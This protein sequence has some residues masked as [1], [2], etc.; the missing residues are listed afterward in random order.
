MRVPEDTDMVCVG[1]R[2]QR[3]GSVP[4]GTSG[5]H[6]AY[7]GVVRNSGNEAAHEPRP[8]RLLD[9]LLRKKKFFLSC[10]HFTGMLLRL[11]QG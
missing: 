2:G 9:S 10:A 1:L 4:P 7:H 3:E 11:W 6:C 5:D 8:H